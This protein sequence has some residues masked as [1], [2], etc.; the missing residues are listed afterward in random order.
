MQFEVL[1]RRVHS[2]EE[3]YLQIAQVDFAV[4]A[5]PQGGDDIAPGDRL[6][7]SDQNSHR[8]GD[9]SEGTQGHAKKNPNASGKMHV[10][11]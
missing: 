8:D 10:R 5:L 9:G 7:T 2:G 1:T 3:G 4:I 11:T 6:E